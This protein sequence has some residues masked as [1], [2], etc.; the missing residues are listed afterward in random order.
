MQSTYMRLSCLDSPVRRAAPAGES[1][2]LPGTP[3]Y[4]LDRRLVL[5]QPV[6]RHSAAVAATTR[7][8]PDVQDVVVPAAGQVPAVPGPG[9]PAHLLAVGL[10]W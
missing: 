7:R 4:R 6:L 2:G 5:G 10:Q 1:A 9:Q 3:G 8:L